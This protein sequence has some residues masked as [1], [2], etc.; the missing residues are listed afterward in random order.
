M[1]TSPRR[2]RSR[3]TQPRVHEHNATAP[4]DGQAHPSRP[5]ARAAN[6][7]HSRP[8]RWLRRG[9]YLS[10]AALTVAAVP[11]IAVAASSGVTYHACVV[12]KT[13]ALRV[14]S[15]AAHCG[16]GQHKISWNS[17][18]PA[19]PKGAT[20]RQGPAGDVAGYYTST[21]NHL[22]LSGTLVSYLTLNLP[23]GNWI[24]QSANEIAST[25]SGMQ[26][27]LCEIDQ[28]GS[29]VTYRDA[30]VSPPSITVESIPN[31]AAISGGGTITLECA[32]IGGSGL[33]YAAS[34]SMA[35]FQVSS[36][37]SQ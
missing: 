30:Q 21:T 3:A 24:V 33:T 6:T 27:D 1:Q 32:Q 2:L 29:D 23:A 15:A 10:A 26:A 35:A 16:S 5:D 34:G 28:N 36:L 14:V 25:A 12:N 37:T 11:A 31:V 22:T 4:A 13:G 9:A 20:G 17:T 7:A 8:R 19:G 18:G